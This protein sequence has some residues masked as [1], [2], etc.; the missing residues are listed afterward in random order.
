MGADHLVI[1]SSDTVEAGD[2]GGFQVASDRASL[3]GPTEVLGADN[4]GFLPDADFTF[5][6]DGNM[7]S[8]Q[9]NPMLGAPVQP[10]DQSHASG[11]HRIS[12]VPAIDELPDLILDDDH[13]ELGGLPVDEA[14]PASPGHAVHQRT[15]SE[16]VVAPVARKKTTK[17]LPMDH[18]TE[19]PG[20]M[21][22]DW[23]KQ[24][25]QNMA[26]ASSNRKQH[27]APSLG[28][29]NARFLILDAGLG[30]IGWG[31]GRG[32]MA[33]PLSQ[34]CGEQL[35]HALIEERTGQKRSYDDM[36][37]ESPTP[38][39]RVRARSEEMARGDGLPFDGDGGSSDMDGMQIE[40]AREEAAPLDDFSS[41]PW[42]V[43]PSARG[44]S[45]GTGHA[46]SVFGSTGRPSSLAGPMAPLGVLPL[47]RPGSRMT[48]PL[49][50]R[51]AHSRAISEG[52]ADAR[53]G[54]G[55]VDGGFEVAADLD[56]DD[57]FQMYGLAAGLTTQDAEDSQTQRAL[58]DTESNNFLGFIHN[59]ILVGEEN[60]VS[61]PSIKFE[62]LLD[63]NT[64]SR[65]VAAQGLLHALSLGTR[66]LLRAEQDTAY[67][68]IVL[69]PL[70]LVA[71]L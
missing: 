8:L 59:A 4:D 16:S 20:Q 66:N 6:A 32:N 12:T 57:T 21:V 63:P 33:S 53:S 26:A 44:S 40:T 7:I 31:L 47:S 48:S 43:R 35:Y 55:F 69:I 49:I 36:T 9:D 13:L 45:I 10:P 22:R 61:S 18:S 29:L 17:K 56:E 24:Y 28:R 50:D 27:Q 3:Q 2:I 68:A 34:F 41:M 71:A 19:L 52:L 70:Q 46:G 5:D 60:S 64:H 54:S 15:S 65:I 58:L 14:E 37:G 67:G 23:G 42:N 38:S 39:R 1:P 51:A 11:E 25:L 30:G 62:E